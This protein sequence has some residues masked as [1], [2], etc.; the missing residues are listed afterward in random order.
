MGVLTRPTVKVGT[1]QGGVHPLAGSPIPLTCS[2]AGVPYLS[3]PQRRQSQTCVRAY[4]D[5]CLGDACHHPSGLNGSL[6]LISNGKG[7]GRC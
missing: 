2:L 3:V 1:L 4:L 5:C 7:S 6:T